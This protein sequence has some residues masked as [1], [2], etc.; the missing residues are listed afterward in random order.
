[1]TPIEEQALQYIEQLAA[2]AVDAQSHFDVYVQE[3]A[4]VDAAKASK[5]TLLSLMCRE[6][7]SI[8][9]QV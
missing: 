7:T 8:Y 4:E 2:V 6:I 1:M 9:Q 5:I 3:I